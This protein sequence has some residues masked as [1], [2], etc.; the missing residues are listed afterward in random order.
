MCINGIVYAKVLHIG[1]GTGDSWSLLWPVT[2]YP[3]CILPSQGTF[4]IYTIQEFSSFLCVVLVKKVE[5][6]LI[7]AFIHGVIILFLI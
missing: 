1:K 2:C 7:L 5:Q 3:P 4:I 6:F